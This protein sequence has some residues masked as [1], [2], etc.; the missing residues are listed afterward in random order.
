MFYWIYDISTAELAIMLTTLFVS[1]SWIGSVLL[2]PV[3]R[4]FV[5][6]RSETNA[7]VGNVLSCHGVYYGLLLGLLAVAAYQNFSQAEADVSA[8]AAAMA[9]I[10]EDLGSY[11]EPDRQYLRWLLRNHCRYII[12]YAWPLQQEG[13]HLLPG[14][15]APRHPASG[16]RTLPGIHPCVPRDNNPWRSGNHRPTY[17]ANAARP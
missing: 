16:D 11:P 14:W 1:F 13:E 3:L 17:S 7:I 4:M 9:A 10:Y 12:H 2:R 15:A 8:E 5:R 6:S